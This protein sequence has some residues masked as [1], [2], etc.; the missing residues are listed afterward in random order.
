MST[1]YDGSARGNQ[2]DI[3]I[4]ANPPERIAEIGALLA[5]KLGPEYL[6]NRPGGGGSKLTYIEAWRVLEMANKVFGWDGEF[7][8]AQRF[9]VSTLKMLTDV[10]YLFT[11]SDYPGAGWFSEIKSLHMNFVS[12]A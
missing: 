2:S 10:E 11:A 12:C 4:R 1:I 5:K 6:S 9:L 8:D 7:Y 3:L